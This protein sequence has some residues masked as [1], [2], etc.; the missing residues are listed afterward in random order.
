M[1]YLPVMLL[2]SWQFVQQQVVPHMISKFCSYDPY[3]CVVLLVIFISSVAC[4]VYCSV[5]LFYMKYMS[6][7]FLQKHFFR[8]VFFWCQHHKLFQL[9]SFSSSVVLYINR[10]ILFCFFSFISSFSSPTVSVIF[11]V[12]LADTFLNFCLCQCSF[13]LVQFLPACSLINFF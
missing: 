10:S 11:Y 6:L 2:M 3:V 12:L 9:F 4:I 1:V 13:R 8:S 7:F 5:F